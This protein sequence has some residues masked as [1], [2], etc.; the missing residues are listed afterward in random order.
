[1]DRA[2]LVLLALSA[3]L[4]GFATTLGPNAAQCGLVNKIGA[5]AVAEPARSATL[6]ILERIAKGENQDIDAAWEKQLGL[7]AGDLHHPA[8]ADIGVR[9]CALHSLGRTGLPE[10]AQFLR[11]F[12]LSDAAGER[13]DRLW[14]AA[15]IALR[16]AR[17]S[18]IADAASRA[19]FLEN[20][21]TEPRDAMS[22]GAVTLWAIEELCDGGATSALPRIRQTLAQLWT[23]EPFAADEA[24]FC[25]DRMQVLSRDTDRAKALGSV[26]GSIVSLENTLEGKRLLQWAMLQLS[27]L[28]TSSANSELE[29]IASDLA[30][31][32]KNFPHDVQLSQTKEFIDG[33]LSVR[34]K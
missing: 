16:E 24:A 28:H 7:T 9:V 13:S 11:G 30:I 6:N 3:P 5:M 31:Q 27:A 19:E 21:L 29:R 14:S 15:Q 34:R 23:G 33:I 32:A 22:K 8:Y 26:F 4:I 1:M 12:S 17:L 10:A 2:S 25:Q 18:G 20:V